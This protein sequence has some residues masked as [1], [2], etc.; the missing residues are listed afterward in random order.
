MHMLQTTMRLEITRHLHRSDIITDAQHS[1]H[2]RHSC[3]TQLI[4]TVGSCRWNWQRWPDWGSPAGLL[5]SHWQVPQKHPLLKL[6]FCGI[7]GRTNRWIVDFLSNKIHQLVVKGEHSYTWSVTSGERQGSI[8]R[9]SLFLIYINYLG[10]RIKSRLYFFAVDTFL[11]SYTRTP[12]NSIQLQ[13]DLRT[14]ESWERRWLMSLHGEMSPNDCDQ[15]KEQDTHQ[16]QP[17]QP[18]TW[19]LP[20][21]SALVYS[22]PRTSTGWEGMPNCCPDTLLQR[23]CAFSARVCNC[24]VGPQSAT[25]EVHIGD[26]AMTVSLPHPS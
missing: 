22:W 4:L 3:E 23:P 12:N 16:L 6:D 1:F 14:L 19:E 10:D 26:G 11:C 18:N 20:V 21:Q 7:R 24:G 13:D 5:K 2:K 15:E 17:P 9:P 25:S 8:L